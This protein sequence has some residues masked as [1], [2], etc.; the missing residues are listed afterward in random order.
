M[1]MPSRISLRASRAAA[2]PCAASIWEL[3]FEPACLRAPTARYAMNR[4]PGGQWRILM[5]IGIA[6]LGRM[7][8]AIAARLIEV[9]H[10]LTVW[11]RS[12]EKAKPLAQAGAVVAGSPAELAG[13][14]ET[15]ITI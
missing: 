13:K 5:Q 12:P 6:G 1:R 8:V 15:V 2:L 14:V 9:G 7:G 11:N 10:T 4:G 3:P